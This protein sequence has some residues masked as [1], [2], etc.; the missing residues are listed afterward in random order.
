MGLPILDILDVVANV[1]DRVI[2]DPKDK[3]ELQEKLATIADQEAARE[4]DEVMGQIGTNT[5]EAANTN[6]FVAGWRPAVGWVCAVGV[7]Y[8]FILEPFMAF[9]AKLA[10][11]AGNFPA[12]DVTNLMTLMMGMLGMGYLRTK[13]KMAGL[14]D[15]NVGTPSLPT[16]APTTPPKKRVLGVAWPF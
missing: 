13:E 10:G 14:P 1:V 9:I 6:L 7:G 12:L 15:S 4:H 5:A 11:Y 2:P 8:S 3:L 16:G